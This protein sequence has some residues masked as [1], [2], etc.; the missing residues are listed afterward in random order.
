MSKFRNRVFLVGY[1]GHAFVVMDVLGQLNVQVVGY[2]DKVNKSE[3]NPYNLKYL[4]SEND[5]DNHHLIEMQGLSFFPAI[6]DNQIRARCMDQMNTMGYSAINAIHPSSIISD[7]NT[8]GQGNLISG[9]TIV[10][11]LVTIGDGVILNTGSIIEHECL[12]N[13]FAHVGPGAVLAGNVTVD[14]GSFIGANSVVREGITI[15]AN[16]VVGAGS[17]VV[18]EVPSNELWLGNPAKK[19]SSLP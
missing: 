2:F 6:G 13:D 14:T 7:Q 16:S 17:V 19:I 12:I 10:N 5:P 8:L 18:K 4:G 15:G 1:S 9:G 3:T 11:P